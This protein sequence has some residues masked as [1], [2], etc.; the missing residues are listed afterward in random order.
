[1]KRFMNLVFGVSHIEVQHPTVTLFNP[2]VGA[3]AKKEGG[4]QCLDMICGLLRYGPGLEQVPIQF[5]Q[6]LLKETNA[7][8]QF[9]NSIPCQCR[10]GR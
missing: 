7:D 6:A 1:M 8:L 10:V 2:L 4:L 5:L 9:G 3:L